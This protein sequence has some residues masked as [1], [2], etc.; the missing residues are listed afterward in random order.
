MISPELLRKYQ[1]FGFLNE[2]EF[3]KV[4]VFA[5]EVTWEKGVVVFNINAKA[6]KLFFLETGEIDLHYKVVD[7]LIS[8]KSKEF[9]V[10]SVNPGDPMGVAALLEPFEYTATGIAVEQ[11]KGIA[12]DAKKLLS[13]ADADPKLG[14]ALM[15]KLSHALFER[16]GQ[17]RVE[18]AAA[19]N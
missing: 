6:D 19:R 3:A 7:E 5:E 4:A 8:D 13:L 14:Y 15:A 16:L 11:S 2:D 18:L 10:G 9:Y 17:V 1:F 12:V